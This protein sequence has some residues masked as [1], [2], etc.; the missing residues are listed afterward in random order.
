MTGLS[1]LVRRSYIMENKEVRILH[2]RTLQGKRGFMSNEMSQKE[3]WEEVAS[4][5]KSIT[6]ECFNDFNKEIQAEIREDNN[7]NEFCEA[8][9][10]RLHETIDSHPWVIYTAYNYDILRHADNDGYAIDNFG[11]ECA[12]VDGV[13]QTGVLAYGALYANVQEHSDFGEV[14]E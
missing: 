11:A 6:E 12:V 4:L 10:D 13:L 9:S 7:H 2:P 5:A 8:L 3:Y 1:Q 14:H